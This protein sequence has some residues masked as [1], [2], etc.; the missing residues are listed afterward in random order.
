[1][2]A[3]R[4][5]EVGATARKFLGFWFL[6]ISLAGCHTAGLS[7]VRS[8]QGYN[9][10]SVD[11]PAPD[12]A[13]V[14]Q[15]IRQTGALKGKRFAIGPFNND[16]GKFNSVAAGATGSFIQTGP[17]LAVYAVEAIAQ[18]GGSAY[19]YSNLDIV[20]NIATVGGK[21][22]ALILN[23]RQNANMPDY[24]IS[25]FATALDF[26]GVSEGDVRV[27]GVGP[28]FTR[29][30]ARAYYAAHIVEPGSQRSLARGYALYRGTF[31]QAGVGSS[32]FFGGGSGTLVSG[33]VSFSIQE[34]LQRPTAEGIMLSVAYAL[35]EI[36]ALKQ[37]RHTAEPFEPKPV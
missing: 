35:L 12:L 3:R 7:K 28:T 5:P 22:A 2:I 17:N 6:S 23:K 13:K 31:T 19:D 32:R 29:T 21:P 9:L 36:P 18:S 25:V 30:A 33:N 1:M 11:R 16:T 4:K 27:A 8:D 20:R 37:C 24:A 26:E 15:C 34:P 14:F 10:P